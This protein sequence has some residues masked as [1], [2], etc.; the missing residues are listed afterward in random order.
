MHSSRNYTSVTRCRN[1]Q[2]IVDCFGFKILKDNHRRRVLLLIKAALLALLEAC[3]FV[4]WQ[5]KS[6]SGV[7]GSRG[8][9][10]R[11]AGLM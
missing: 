8:T 11:G 2:G 7:L 9:V 1:L 5:D 6:F 3:E 4:P 10:I